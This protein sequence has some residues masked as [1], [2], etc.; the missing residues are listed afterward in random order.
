VGGSSTAKAPCLLILGPW[1]RVPP[2]SPIYL[3]ETERLS[4][5]RQRCLASSFIGQQDIDRT[6]HRPRDH[7]APGDT[8][9]CPAYLSLPS[10]RSRSRR[11]RRDSDHHTPSFKRFVRRW[12]P[13]RSARRAVSEFGCVLQ[14]LRLSGTRQ[15]RISSSLSPSSKVSCRWVLVDSSSYLLSS[16]PQSTSR[17][18]CNWLATPE[19]H[20]GKRHIRGDRSG[21]N[22]RARLG[23][24]TCRLFHSDSEGNRRGMANRW[25]KDLML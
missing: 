15:L 2:G 13:R 6:E 12:V 10:P 11:D 9:A 4:D 23:L 18:I 1:V 16:R 21:P 7:Q 24:A 20:L 19:P 3:V 5:Q 8:D 22:R 14:A 25:Q 17:T